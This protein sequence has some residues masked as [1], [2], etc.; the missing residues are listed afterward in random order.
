MWEVTSETFPYPSKITTVK[1]NFSFSFFLFVYIGCCFCF[2]F[3]LKELKSCGLSLNSSLPPSL[4]SF[5][6]CLFLLSL[7]LGNQI[8]KLMCIQARVCTPLHMCIHKQY[9]TV[10][11][12]FYFCTNGMRMYLASG[13]FFYSL[14]SY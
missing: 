14:Y 11:L 3:F 13:N 10:F 4:P 6:P 8:M 7:P 2:R 5:Y 9:V 1:N 12:V